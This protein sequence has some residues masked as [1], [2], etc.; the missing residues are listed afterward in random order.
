MVNKRQ[1][2]AHQ[3]ISAIPGTGGIVTVIANRVGC[4]RKTATWYI[5]N[6][7]TVKAAYDAEREAITDMAEGVV[8]GN[9]QL[10]H[11]K[12]DEKDNKKQVDSG[13]AKWYLSRKGKN[14]GYTERTEITGA[15]GGDL[16]IAVGKKFQDALDKV[17]NDE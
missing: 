10:A 7:P 17:Y 4:H 11:D 15:D 14:R 5:E 12:L 9:I 16:S 6:Y 3:F 2:K 8:L 1:Y 13:D